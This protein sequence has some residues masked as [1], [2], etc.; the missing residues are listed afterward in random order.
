MR[1]ILQKDVEHRVKALNVL[2]KHYE[3]NKSPDLYTAAGKL[4]T[5]K[6]NSDWKVYK[7]EAQDLES[8]DRKITNVGKR[9]PMRQPILYPARRY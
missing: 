6:E 8:D 3:L 5:P 7:K 4:L 9:F 1:K 2:D